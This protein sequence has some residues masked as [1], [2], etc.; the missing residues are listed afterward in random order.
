[1]SIPYEW[2]SA[3]LKKWCEPF[4]SAPPS[5]FHSDLL[6]RYPDNL[7]EF[8]ASRLD[9]IA[10]ASALAVNALVADLRRLA[11]T[12]SAAEE[13]LRPAVVL[14][15]ENR[16]PMVNGRLSQAK[17][18]KTRHKVVSALL[19]GYPVALGKTRSYGKARSRMRSMF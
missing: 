18:T 19:R 6:A 15:G 7:P 12:A 13:T 17:L 2:T 8:F 9:G 5:R 1:M 3:Q 16:A 11:E 10:T 14:R 4:S